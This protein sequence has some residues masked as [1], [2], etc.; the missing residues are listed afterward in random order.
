MS[1][2]RDCL[3]IMIRAANTLKP[4][5]TNYHSLFVCFPPDHRADDVSNPH[6]RMS[7]GGKKSAVTTGSQDATRNEPDRVRH[8]SR[9]INSASRRRISQCQSRL[10]SY[11]VYYPT[12]CNRT[13]LLIDSPV[14]DHR[15]CGNF[16]LARHASLCGRWRS[17]SCGYSGAF[18]FG[19]LFCMRKLSRSGRRAPSHASHQ[20]RAGEFLC[21]LRQKTVSRAEYPAE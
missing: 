14:P 6:Y 2:A 21:Q 15:S 19:P 8:T 13:S 4:L 7:P 11:T 12:S 16:R 3:N 10:Q 5:P 1:E 17:G 9:L 18:N 20:L